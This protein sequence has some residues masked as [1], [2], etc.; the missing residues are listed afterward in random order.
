MK[1]FFYNKSELGIHKFKAA[2][3]KQK[4]FVS[5]ARFATDTV[6][7]VGVKESNDGKKT[8]RKWDMMKRQ[9]MQQTR[10]KFTMIKN[11]EITFSIYGRSPT[12]KF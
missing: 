9:I 4:F 1:S 3:K 10:V 2:K 6:G 12:F 8:L 11:Y 7:S 5:L